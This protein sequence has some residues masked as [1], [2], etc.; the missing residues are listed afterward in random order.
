MP[1]LVLAVVGVIVV[2]VAGYLISG[3]MTS[4]EDRVAASVLR[5]C[6]A[7]NEGSARGFVEELADRYDDKQF[8]LNRQTLRS[9]LNQYFLAVRQDGENFRYVASV[10]ESTLVV[11]IEEEK[12]TAVF[13]AS[14]T[15]PKSEEP[16]WTGSVTLQYEQIDG[17]WLVV[18]SEYDNLVGRMPLRP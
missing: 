12:A 11:T 9:G 13:E 5:I 3:W 7:F 8:G 4:D 2:L 14:L 15:R 1:K 6:D 10:D 16:T 18:I 17:E